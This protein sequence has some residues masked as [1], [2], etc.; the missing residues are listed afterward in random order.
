MPLLR[1]TPCSVFLDESIP[2]GTV[3]LSRDVIK[4]RRLRVGDPVVIR[5]GGE[6]VTVRAAVAEEL[7]KCQMAMHPLLSVYLGAMEGATVDVGDPITVGE[8]TADVAPAF[9]DVLGSDC[10][11][12]RPRLGDELDHFR[13]MTVREVLDHIHRYGGTPSGRYLV[14]GPNREGTGIPT[15]EA[16]EDPSLSVKEWHPEE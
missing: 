11:V 3:E 7:G 9:D 5:R 10:E 14:V 13:G 12:L 8:V 2:E 16:C 15:G 6:P 4:K 1:A